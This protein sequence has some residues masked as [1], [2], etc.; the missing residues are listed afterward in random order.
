MRFHRT[1]RKRLRHPVV[2]ELDLS[3]EAM[4]VPGEDLT[5]LVYTAE[6]GSRTQEALDLLASWAATLDQ[7]QGLM[8]TASTW[9]GSPPATWSSPRSSGPTAPA[10]SATKGF[11]PHAATA[12]S[13]AATVSTGARA[14][15]SGS[16][17]RLARW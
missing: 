9:P 3:F 14:K 11:R 16:L 7:E 4:E 6:P 1:G 17:R 8:A 10:T 13:G 2:G 12:A 5:M 15:P